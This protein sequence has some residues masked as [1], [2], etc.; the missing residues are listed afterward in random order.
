ML[1]NRACAGDFQRVMRQ[2]V[3]GFLRQILQQNFQR[4]FVNG[5]GV[6]AYLAEQHGFC[7]PLNGEIGNLF[8]RRD[9]PPGQASAFP[10]H[11]SVRE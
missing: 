2:A 7:L 1:A 8:G 6:S 3:A 9:N 11:S 10:A 4:L 5:F